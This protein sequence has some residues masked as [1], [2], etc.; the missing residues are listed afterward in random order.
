MAFFRKCSLFTALPEEKSLYGHSLFVFPSRCKEGNDSVN[1]FEARSPALTVREG[2]DGVDAKIQSRQALQ[3][4][5]LVLRVLSG[6]GPATTHRTAAG[7]HPAA[8]LDTAAFLR[9]E[10]MSQSM[11]RST[12]NTHDSTSGTTRRI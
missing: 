7:I 3:G 1:S 8:T 11:S 10:T 6:G 9:L 2:E 4:G 5:L 12:V